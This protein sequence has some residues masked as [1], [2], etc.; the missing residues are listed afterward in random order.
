MIENWPAAIVVA[1]IVL[2]F[3]IY[4]TASAWFA[5]RERLAKIEHGID[6]DQPRQPTPRQPLSARV[7]QLADDPAGKIQA[8]K[9]YREETG[10]SLAE[11]KK[12]VEEYIN[13]T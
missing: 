1:A 3:A 2:A 11:A 8:I 10:A 6:P 9:V 7:Q 12:A 13:S 4:L 5:H